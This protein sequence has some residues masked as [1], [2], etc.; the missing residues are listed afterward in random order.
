MFTMDGVDISIIEECIGD[1]G[2]M[3]LDTDRESFKVL[4]G[5]FKK[6]IGIWGFLNE[7]IDM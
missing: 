4:M 1:N 3:G 5:R 7:I 6:E 2:Q